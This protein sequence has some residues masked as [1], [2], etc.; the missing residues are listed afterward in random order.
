[1]AV[2]VGPQEISRKKMRTTMSTGRHGGPQNPKF[3]DTKMDNKA[4]K[5]LRRKR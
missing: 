3:Q 2:I 4:A 1:M 5:L